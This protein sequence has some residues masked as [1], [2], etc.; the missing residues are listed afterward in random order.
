MARDSNT[1][2]HE[3]KS[4]PNSSSN[5]GRGSHVGRRTFMKTIGAAF[6]SAGAIAASSRLTDGAEYETITVPA[7]T[8]KTIN[9]GD[10][11]TFE[12]KLIDMTADGASV[13]ILTSGSGW[14]IRNVGFKG[15]HPG[16][17]YLMIPGVADA[18]GQGLIENVYMG[19]GQPDGSLKGAIWVNANMPHRGT[20]TFRNFHMG[21]LI[22]GL[23]ASG[24]GVMGAGGNI[25]V[26]SSY[27]YSNSV[28]NIRT[29]G[30]ERSNLIK[31]TVV[32]V[33]GSQ[34]ALGSDTTAPGSKITRGIWSWY[35][36]C[37]L[38]NCDIVGEFATSKNGSIT[39]SNTRTGDQADTTPPAG[40]PMSAEE[41]ASGSSTTSD[42]TPT[43]TDPSNLSNTLSIS[44]GTASTPTSYSFAVSDAIEKSTDRNASI[45]AEDTI[46][47]G[48]VEGI[49]AGG[50]DSYRFSGTISAFSI[51]GDA[52]VF[53]ND[54]VVDPTSLSDGTDSSQSGSKHVIID[55]SGSKG[56]C[57]Y[58]F[59]V[60]GGDVEKD[61][62]HG[63][64]NS[65]DT[66]SNGT[67][68]GRVISG[69]DAYRYTGTVT[70]FNLE[71]TA[72]VRFEDAK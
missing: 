21:H 16:G 22:N 57:Q 17:N 49:V 20:I 30:L 69:K 5:E 33:D 64:I 19:D 55:G 59:E 54:E 12:N 25:Q 50:T 56:A 14:T 7:G 2:R 36:D 3:R 39:Q 47:D 26:E 41:A 67:V 68:T 61:A 58:S 31:D 72:I 60:E 48:S 13:K 52:T 62:E 9:V 11:E 18:D 45:S 65:F 4:E 29:N 28:A 66:I 38:E 63:S 15:E 23:Y 51:D 37:H 44:G 6:A 53:H 1:K 70:K 46:T 40:V 43:T 10:G 71:G 24:P 34:P 35:G 42:D 32:H 27:F 8:V